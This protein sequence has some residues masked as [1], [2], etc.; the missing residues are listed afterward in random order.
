MQV[1]RLAAVIV[2]EKVDDEA[3]H[4]KEH[5]HGMPVECCACIS[6][7]R[8]VFPAEPAAHDQPTLLPW[9]LAPH[10][11]TALPSKRRPAQDKR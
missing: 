10:S 7:R 4:K 3:E 1:A 2:D 11:N 9:C 5:A 6:M 8:V